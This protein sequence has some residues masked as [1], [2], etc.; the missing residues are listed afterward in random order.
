MAGNLRVD[1]D[2]LAVAKNGYGMARPVEIRSNPRLLAQ[3]TYR[4]VKP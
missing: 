1:G 4:R 3:E 2:T